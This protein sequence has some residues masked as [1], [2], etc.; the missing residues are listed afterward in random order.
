MFVSLFSPHLSNNTTFLFYKADVVKKKILLK[1]SY[2]ILSWFYYLR[3]IETTSTKHDSSLQFFVLP[4]KQQIY[5]LTQAPIAHK[6]WAREQYKFHFYFIRISFKK[7]V[8]LDETINNFNQALLFLLLLK[9]KLP[10]FETNLLFLKNIRLMI[11]V[12]DTNY[13]NYYNFNNKK[14]L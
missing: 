5:T 10:I 6:T 8:I 9:Q 11:A 3:T 12:I 1:E 7:S 13:F 2:I 4:T 14:Y